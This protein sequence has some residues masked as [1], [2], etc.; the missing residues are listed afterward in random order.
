MSVGIFFRWYLVFD[1]DMGVLFVSL[2][3]SWLLVGLWV[4]VVF[5][6]GYG[7]C[8]GL[9]MFRFWCLCL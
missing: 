3:R 4:G 7:F 6:R 9:R 8:R 5:L 2:V 1:S